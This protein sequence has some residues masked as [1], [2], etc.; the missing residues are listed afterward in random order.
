MAEVYSN[1]GIAYYFHR[2]PREAVQV[3]AKALQLNP[4]L[5]SALI[6]SGIAY[7]DLSDTTH[8]LRALQQ[9]VALAPAD[10]LAH[11]WLGFILI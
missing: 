7:Y 8:A 6:F 5:V 4:N 10:P 9:A 3:F 2:Q 1:L 11:T